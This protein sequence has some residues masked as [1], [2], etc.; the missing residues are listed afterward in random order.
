[1][2]RKFSDVV[3]VTKLRAL[4]Q[5]TPIDPVATEAASERDRLYFEAHPDEDEYLRDYIP[6][7]FVVDYGGSPIP[8]LV[9]VVQLEPGVRVRQGVW[10]VRLTTDD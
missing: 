9:R 5:D 10:L 1:M 6:D 7:E 8:D 3:D 2:K 4:P